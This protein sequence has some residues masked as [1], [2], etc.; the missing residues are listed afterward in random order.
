MFSLLY[1][2]FEYIFRKDEFHILILGVDKAG[3][4][5]V[6]KACPKLHAF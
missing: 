3:K 5:N 4:T 2:F 6:S 1:G